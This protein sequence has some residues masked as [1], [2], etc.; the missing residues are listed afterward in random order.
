MSVRGQA[1]KAMEGGIVGVLDGREGWRRACIVKGGGRRVGVA[2]RWGHAA[3]REAELRRRCIWLDR[4][5]FRSGDPQI[6]V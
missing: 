2:D 1:Q 5:L 4:T 6:E 3:E